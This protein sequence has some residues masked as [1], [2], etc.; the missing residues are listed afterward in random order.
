MQEQG[1]SE[2]FDLIVIGGGPGGGPLSTLVAKEGHRV[3]V[4]E[5][6]KFPRYAIGESLIPATAHGIAG[7]LGIREELHEQGYP[8]KYGACFRWGK[9][10]EP[11][12]FDFGDLPVLRSVDA[13]YAYQVERSKFDD[14]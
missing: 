10:P 2:D 9:S 4:L 1:D 6:E 11:W 14:L 7:L 5:R 8:V 3:L 13:G 12:C